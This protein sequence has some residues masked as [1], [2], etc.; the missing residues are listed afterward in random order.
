MYHVDHL[1]RNGDKHPSA[2]GEGVK[3]KAMFQA[4]KVCKS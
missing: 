1:C 3:G 2:L 4:G